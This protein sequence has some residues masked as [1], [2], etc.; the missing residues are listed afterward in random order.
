MEQHAINQT[1]ALTAEELAERMGVSLRH[2]RRLDSSGQLPKP[3]R[4]GR[5]VRWPVSEIEAWLA[6]GAPGR[7]AWQAMKG[8]MV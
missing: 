8:A 5:S 7:E 2:V 6:A 3:V 1:L 4:L